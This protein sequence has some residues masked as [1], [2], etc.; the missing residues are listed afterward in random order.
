MTKNRVRTL[1][2]LPILAALLA[3]C[4]GSEFARSIQRVNEERESRGTHVVLNNPTLQAKAQ[5]WAEVLASQGR[6]VHSNLADGVGPGWRA[7][8]ENLATAG[9]IDRAHELLMSSSAHRSTLLSG[10]YDSIGVGVASADGRYYVVQV[11]GG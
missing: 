4:Q 7:L 9:S 5:Q 8:G 11:F 2:A 3:A 1:V 6:L 10:R